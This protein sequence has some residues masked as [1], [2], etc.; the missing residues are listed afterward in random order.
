MTGTKNPD[1][2]ESGLNEKVAPLGIEPRFWVPETH[3]LSIVLRSQNHDSRSG[4]LVE[5]RG[6]EPR[7]SCM[8]CKR[9]SQLSY[10]PIEC[11][12]CLQPL[13]KR[14]AKIGGLFASFQEVCK[15][16]LLRQCLQLRTSPSYGLPTKHVRDTPHPEALGAIDE[17]RIHR[18]LI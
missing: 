17:H 9:S 6:F 11:S 10:T 18:L 12:A 14:T 2:R 8:P 13:L 4:L 15:Q 16:S 7:T 5:I 1:S 3:A